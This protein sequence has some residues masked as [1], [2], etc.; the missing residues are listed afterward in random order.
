VG[1]R[2]SQFSPVEA[3]ERFHI[4]CRGGLSRPYRHSGQQHRKREMKMSS[5]SSRN[6]A[7][8]EGHHLKNAGFSGGYVLRSGGNGWFSTL[9]WECLFLTITVKF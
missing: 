8:D 5:G 3:L 1:V 6:A 9:S 4:G 7:L 2:T